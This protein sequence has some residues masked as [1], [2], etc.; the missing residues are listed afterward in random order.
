MAKFHECSPWGTLNA[1][2]LVTASRNTRPSVADPS[3]PG[4]TYINCPSGEQVP[5]TLVVISPFLLRYLGLSCKGTLIFMC[6][7]QST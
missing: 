1:C 6:S 5:S 2:L 4:K 7:I 3:H